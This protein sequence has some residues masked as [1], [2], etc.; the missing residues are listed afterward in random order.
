MPGLGFARKSPA[1]PHPTRNVCAESSQIG[2]ERH[3]GSSFRA[4]PGIR[5][6]LGPRRRRDT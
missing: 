4:R 2:E 5:S 6:S 3:T 1:L